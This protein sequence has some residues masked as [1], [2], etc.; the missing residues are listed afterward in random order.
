MDRR[1]FLVG[2]VGTACLPALA[3]A[4][5]GERVA[6]I[7]WLD[8]TSSG[9]NRGVFVQAMGARGWADGS[10]Q[11]YLGLQYAS[12]GRDFPVIQDIIEMYRDE[13]KDVPV[14][15]GGVY[16]NRGVL[17]AAVIVEAIRLAVY[18]VKGTGWVPVSGWI[19][20]YR[21]EVM[22]IVKEENAKRKQ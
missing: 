1:G 18:Q 8:Y 17:N 10:A 21:D 20:D 14:Y 7:G 6:R 9:E 13:R 12:V 4:Q 22:T 11:G 16:Y 2:A 5:R 19:R 3:G 15:L